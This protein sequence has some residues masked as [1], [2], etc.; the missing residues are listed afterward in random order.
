MTN[1]LIVVVLLA[2]G[3]L[4][5]PASVPAQTR[6]GKAGTTELSGG[7]S[8]SSYTPVSNGKTSDATTL[9][10]FGPEI[11]YF[12]ADGF[13]IGFDPGMS[14]L[15]GI[16]VATP[17]K[18]DGTTILQ[19]F[20]YPAYN[21]LV[22]GSR[23]TPFIQ[24]PV[25]YTSMSSGSM[26]NSGFSWGVKGGVKVSGAENF[27][28]TVYGEYLQIAFTPEKATERSGFNFLSFGVA[29]GGFF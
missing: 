7:I 22:E 17:S 13:E 19:L 24:V 16:S 2:A 12:V 9:L 4:G 21:I 26:T 29:F 3:V 27:L 11:G 18:G 8:F 20:V 6:F 1:R 5:L 10:S 25:G 28:V 23:M 15:P 14:L